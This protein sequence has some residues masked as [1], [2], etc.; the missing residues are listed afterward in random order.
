M[1]PDLIDHVKKQGYKSFADIAKADRETRAF[2]GLDKASIVKVPKVDRNTDPQAWAEFDRAIG[3]PENG[4]YKPWQPQE[5]QLAV[6]EERLKAFDQAIAKVGAS[7]QVRDATLDAFHKINA[8]AVAE[9]DEAF[10]KEKAEGHRAL[11]E[12]WGHEYQQRVEAAG[13]ALSDLPGG[14]AFDQLMKDYGLS[15]HPAAVQA[16]A[17][18]ARLR[19]EGGRP[20]QGEAQGAPLDVAAAKAKKAELLGNNEF[21]QRYF[22]G[23]QAAVTQLLELNAIIQGGR[24]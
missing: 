18:I 11:K 7:Q 5:G 20:P 22:H 12:S 9:A 8:Q 21:A 4:G 15:D 14:S 1:P 19:G 17:E 24:S 3:V 10:A 2:V 16:L 6:N 13:K 23:E